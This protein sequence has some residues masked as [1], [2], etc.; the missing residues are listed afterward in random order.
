[1]SFSSRVRSIGLRALAM[2]AM[3]GV[4]LLSGCG[5]APDPAPVTESTP[6]VQPDSP[7]A[8]VDI[9]PLTPPAWATGSFTV[10]DPN[11]YTFTV[12]ASAMTTA[13][14]SSIADAKPGRAS[15]SITFQA[16][17]ALTNTTAGRNA[18]MSQALAELSMS[19]LWASSSPVCAQKGAVAVTSTDGA[20]TGVC[21]ITSGALLGRD[22]TSVAA[23]G[24]IVKSLPV[25]AKFDVDESTA[26]DLV[27]ALEAPAGWAVAADVHMKSTSAAT[28]R[29]SNPS[30]ITSDPALYWASTPIEGCSVPH[31]TTYSA[32]QVDSETV[33]RALATIKKLSARTTGETVDLGRCPAGSVA[34]VTRGVSGIT[35]TALFDGKVNDNDTFAVSCDTGQ[36]GLDFGVDGASTGSPQQRANFYA[37]ATGT[38]ETDLAGGKLYAF[39][40]PASADGAACQAI[41]HDGDLV[42]R[43]II[44]QYTDATQAEKL[45][46]LR[47]WFAINI[48]TILTNVANEKKALP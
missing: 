31:I 47:N 21:A 3:G 11:D 35:A 10:S 44:S 6:V 32:P 29:L 48:P 18:P 15:V 37:S 43:G 7:Y 27:A 23:G 14:S 40:P 34:E 16:D 25:T 2:G 41:W 33:S 22:S 39:C 24:S 38:S 42:V 13:T 28:C 20:A 46:R 12:A 36:L 17:V 1:M 19:G 9:G 5:A 4:L 30:S 45:T 8:V 26:P